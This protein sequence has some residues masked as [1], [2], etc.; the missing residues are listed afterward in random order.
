MSTTS[1]SVPVALV[2]TLRD[3]SGVSMK[4]AKQALVAANNDLARARLI[5]SGAA[6][7]APAP[8]PPPVAAPVRSGGRPTVNSLHAVAGRRLN[9]RIK[10]AALQQVRLRQ[11]IE[12][13]RARRKGLGDGFLVKRVNETTLKLHRVYDPQPPRCVHVTMAGYGEWL[14]HTV[15]APIV[16]KINKTRRLEA[17]K[18][19]RKLAKIT[20]ENDFDAYRSKATYRVVTT[21]TGR[22]ARAAHAANFF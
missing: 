16:L 3:E 11:R 22:K 18:E 10:Q 13:A 4:E 12:E 1:I 14:C 15:Q 17:A 21:R 6:S 5:L 8:A 9:F 2:R 20:G 19:A 7:T